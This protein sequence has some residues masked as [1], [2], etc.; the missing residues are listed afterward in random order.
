MSAA[1]NAKPDIKENMKKH[2]NYLELIQNNPLNCVLKALNRTGK[3]KLNLS[4]IPT[5]SN[6]SVKMADMPPDFKFYISETYQT[7][8]DK[9][10]TWNFG[11]VKTCILEPS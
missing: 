5:N 7:P 6:P 1:I 11:R 4:R 2:V 3:V 8:N 10:N 9:Q